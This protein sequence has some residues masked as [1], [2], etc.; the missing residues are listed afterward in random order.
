MS[1]LLV[2][3]F[4]LFVFTHLAAAQ[5][6][7][8]QYVRIYNLIQ[9]AD[10]LR[11]SG[12]DQSALSKY[13]E[14][15]SGLTQIQRVH[16][17]WQPKVVSFRLNYLATKI[18]AVQET[19]PAAKLPPT[20]GTPDKTA[21]PAVAPSAAPPDAAAQQL[22]ELQNAVKQLQSEK[23]V[24][25]SK[26]KEALATQPATVDPREL[27]KAQEQVQALAKE[28]ELLKA[29]L[30]QEKNR[31]TPAAVSAKE[32]ED[33]KR[34]LTET[35]ARLVEQQ[36]RNEKLAAE[37]TSLQEQLGTAATSGE[38]VAALRVENEL[39]KKQLG[40]A[41]SQAATAADGKSSET[42][43]KLA[44]AEARLAEM[45]SSAEVLRLEKIALE[46]RLKQTP[47]PAAAVAKSA[48]VASS[49]DAARVK[50]LERQRDALYKLLEKR[51]RDAQDAHPREQ[52]AKIEQLTREVESLKSR[53]EVFETKA[54][55]YSAE[56]LALFQQSQP[57][58]A[59]VPVA[60][61]PKVEVSS[62]AKPA[63]SRKPAKELP[64]GTVALAA[65]AE[66]HFA[67]KQYDQAEV[68]YQ[69]ILRQDEGNAATLANLAAIQMEQGRLPEAET[70]IL[71]A[72]AIAPEHPHANS[73]LGYLKFRQ[74]KYDEAVGALNRAAKL[75]PQNADIQ[76]YLGVTLSQKG[77][78]GPAE[79]AFRKAIVLDSN[80]G[81]AQNNL[82]VFYAAENP[83]NV[84]LARFHYQKA[85]AAGHP[86]DAEIEALFE[87]RQSAPTAPATP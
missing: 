67:A 15:Q 22:A 77:L 38:V 37:K 30:E 49:S 44:E 20:T 68:N 66:K 80:H 62:A 5:S 86:R 58:P 29:G 7:E 17:T 56:E 24:L 11:A 21:S 59:L 47:A 18:T 55:P 48:T 10:A 13:L 72:L 64:A 69:A 53:L 76:N 41:K 74:E 85:L 61:P 51:G 71:R 23:M 50:E 1:R 54:I 40:E 63:D 32:L 4:G 79:Q 81:G 33:A 6:A 45:A 73:L 27:A 28:N 78:R 65:Q 52:V 70:N 14:A 84:A 82:A 83:P 75:N 36:A 34:M 26:L 46:S 39:L 9:E 2:L 57:K 3:L 25:E 43:R 19:A 35:N 8:Q 16:P 42:A 31:P 60:V 12:D 87:K